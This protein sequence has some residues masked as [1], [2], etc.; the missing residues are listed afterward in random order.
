MVLTLRWGTLVMQCCIMTGRVGVWGSGEE[1]QANRSVCRDSCCSD[2]RYSTV[3][4][5]WQV[6]REGRAEGARAVERERSRK[7]LA[8]TTG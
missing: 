2:T 8:P 4:V 6:R 5:P 3:C 7:T 1:V